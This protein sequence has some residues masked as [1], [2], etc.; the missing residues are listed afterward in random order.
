MQEKRMDGLLLLIFFDNDHI[1]L[2]IKDALVTLGKRI[3]NLRLNHL[4]LQH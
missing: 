3:Q 2:V 1:P 4:Y